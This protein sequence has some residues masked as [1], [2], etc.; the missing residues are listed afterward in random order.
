MP[1]AAVRTRMGWRP[2]TTLADRLRMVRRA[3]ADHLGR[4]VSQREMADECGWGRKAWAAYEA[5]INEPRDLWQFA[6]KV[7]QVTGVDPT[8]L[9]D[10]VGDGGAPNTQDVR[11]TR[12]TRDE[13]DL[14]GREAWGTVL[15]FPAAA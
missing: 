12:C 7:A 2:P 9:A 14:S 4:A 1:V 3:Y 15:A 11:T 6:L 5:G 10:S 13:A 8:W